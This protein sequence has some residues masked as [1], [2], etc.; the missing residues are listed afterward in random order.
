MK[1]AR[2]SLDR[3]LQMIEEDNYCVDIATQI[4][5]VQGLLK[6]ANKQIL[7]NHL[8]GCGKTKLVSQDNTEVDAFIEELVRVWDVSTRK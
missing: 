7:K 1:K 6:E 3:I 4:N 5:A 8:K 2:G